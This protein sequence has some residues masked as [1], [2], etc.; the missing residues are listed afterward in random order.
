MLDALFTDVSRSKIDELK[1]VLSETTAPTPFPA[2]LREA[3]M[4]L[5]V[6][7]HRSLTVG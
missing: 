4:S 1:T 7:Q 2:R 6:Q 5:N 3:P